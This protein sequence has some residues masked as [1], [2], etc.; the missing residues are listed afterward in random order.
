MIVGLKNSGLVTAKRNAFQDA[1]AQSTRF[2]SYALCFMKEPISD[3][4]LKVP[5]TEGLLLLS[6]NDSS[7]IKQIFQVSFPKKIVYL[8]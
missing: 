7:M 3:F 6:V 1:A 5:V 4:A 8:A 2:F